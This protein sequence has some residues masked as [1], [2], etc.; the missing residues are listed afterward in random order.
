ML[1]ESAIRRLA[2]SVGFDDCLTAPAARL[3][4]EAA[5]MDSWV[6]AGFA[7]NMTYLER[8]RELRYDIRRLVPGAKT[9]VV[10]LLGF[11]KS[12]H[13]YHR[14]VKSLIYNLQQTIEDY[15]KENDLWQDD[16]ISPAQHIF[17]DSAPVLE[18]SWA[19]RAGLGFFGLN[20]QLI[21]P[22]LGSLVHPG[23]LVL[24]IPCFQ[25]VER[26]PLPET[27]IQCMRCVNA[28]PAKALGQTDWDARR[29]IAYTTHRCLVCQEVCPYNTI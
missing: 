25:D 24:N 14:T 21:H 19:V 18:R 23:E 12:G 16:W 7:G 29:C 26:K 2:L 15:L 17:C 6:D 3:D 9:V 8:N 11:A 4:K 13:D 22:T 27:C 5:Y 10:C 1:R 28:C 20:R